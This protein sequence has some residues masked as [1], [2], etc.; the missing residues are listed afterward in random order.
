MGATF[1]KST[2]D[3]TGATVV[4]S[5]VDATGAT[6]VKM[7]SSGRSARCTEAARVSNQRC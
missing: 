3:A 4:K 6:V 5:T 1:V 7:R 2:V